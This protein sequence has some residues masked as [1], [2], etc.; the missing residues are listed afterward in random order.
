MKN[1]W[2]ENEREKLKNIRRIINLI[3][4]LNFF[5]S[6]KVIT[7]HMVRWTNSNK[8]LLQKN[9]VNKVNVVI[10]MGKKIGDPDPI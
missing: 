4:I 10:R 7:K 5:Y 6:K 3:S 9:A 8:N 2:I 1:S